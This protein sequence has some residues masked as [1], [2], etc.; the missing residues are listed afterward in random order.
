MLCDIWSIGI[1]IYVLVTGEIPVTT[2]A[3]VNA[4]S[5]DEKY[6]ILYELMRDIK[7][8]EDE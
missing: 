5:M 6:K 3:F 8:C 2:E 1:T 7:R 4:T